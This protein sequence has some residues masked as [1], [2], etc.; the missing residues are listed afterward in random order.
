M[1]GLL[2]NLRC[3]RLIV[4]VISLAGC[5]T[6]DLDGSDPANMA[7]TVEAFL[8]QYLSAL[9]RHDEAAVRA[10]YVS[11]GRFSWIEDGRVRYRS[12]DEVLAGLRAIP[13][14]ARIRTELT[15]LTIVPLGSNGAH[16]W[17]SF[18]TT[19][20]SPPSGFAFAG[21][22]SFVLERNGQTWAIVGGHS[23]SEAR[24]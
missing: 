13:R 23:S 8:G 15:G 17:A 12:V 5:A 9:E 6:S 24:R 19:I 11:D 1:R 3:A 16:A 7:P 4:G 2:V 14:G 20:G 18:R 21:A 22:L 10:A